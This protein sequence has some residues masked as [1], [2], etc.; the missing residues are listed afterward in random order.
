[1]CVCVLARQLI[2]LK[3]HISGVDNN[4]KC[5]KVAST[6]L[7]CDEEIIFWHELIAALCQA[8][9]EG[10]GGIQEVLSIDMTMANRKSFGENY[11]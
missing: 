7:V 10:G 1:M 4:N 6:C 8:R 2:K 5:S 9:D 3:C 11:L